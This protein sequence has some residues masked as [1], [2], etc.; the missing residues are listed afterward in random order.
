MREL[1][2]RVFAVTWEV[3]ER[4]RLD[5]D[6]T[7]LRHTISRQLSAALTVV[8]PATLQRL[9]AEQL[10]LMINAALRNQLTLA[11]LLEA[12]LLDA[13]QRA[14]TLSREIRARRD[15][16]AHRERRSHL[17]RVK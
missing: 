1:V 13:G 7:A 12:T 16:I 14:G 8:T 6:P 3:C 4:E 5:A 10:A 9:G 2:D 11:E 15:T 17:H